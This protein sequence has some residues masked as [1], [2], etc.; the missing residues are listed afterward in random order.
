MLKVLEFQ[1]MTDQMGDLPY[2]EA[3]QGRDNLKPKY[4]TQR[5]IY[6]A[7]LSELDAALTSMDA[8]KSDVFG[9]ADIF[10][11]GNVA[12]WKKFGYTL[13]MR[14]GMRISEIEPTLSR[15]WV[16]KAAAGGVMIE[17]GDIAFI[18]YA[19]ITGQF[20][21]RT[22]FLIRDNYSAPGG[23]NYEGG[24]WAHTFID[25]LK[26][27][28]DPRL[29]VISVVWVPQYNG[30]T[31]T[32]YFPDN[33][34]ANQRGMVNGSLNYRP[35]DFDSYSEPS[36]L[37]IYRGAPEVVL[38]P[39]EAYLLRA[40]AALRGWNVG[41]TDAEAYEKAVRCAMAR[42]SLWPDVAPFPNTGRI[43]ESAV[44]EYLQKNPY[45]DGGTLEEQFQQIH[46]Q[47]FILLK[48]IKIC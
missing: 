42:W 41:I 3:M 47:K 6:L 32:G 24:K 15:Q 22:D 38:E 19:D 29:P 45:L 5:S 44:D 23:D 9:K 20:N 27:T 33:V 18:Q 37:Y 13:M 28:E 1:R 14:L 34:P 25:H 7:M 8:S 31:L 48:S 46:R 16:E 17:N 11:G 40:E 36:L 43:S 4:D 26:K 10:Y 30:T 35:D 21:P 12:K 39:A 2:S